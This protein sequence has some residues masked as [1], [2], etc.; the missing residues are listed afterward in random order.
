M[1]KVLIISASFGSGHVKAAEAVKKALIIRDST[2]KV[3]SIDALDYSD[4]VFKKVLPS[5]YLNIVNKFPWV[6]GYIY[7]RYNYSQ[8]EIKELGVKISEEI[9]YVIGKSNAAPL[10]KHIKDFNSQ[11]VV[12]THFFP[13]KIISELKSAGMLNCYIDPIFSEQFDKGKI[14]QKFNLEKSLPAILVLGGAAGRSPFLEIIESLEDVQGTVQILAVAG[15][16]KKLAQKLEI[17]KAKLKNKITVFGYAR[18]M[19]ELMRVSDILITKAG[20]LTVSEALSVDLPMLIVSP[21]PGQE[22]AN[23][24]FLIESGAAKIVTNIDLIGYKVNKILSN[25]QELS[26]MRL[27][28]HKIAKPHAAKEVVDIIFS[29]LNHGRA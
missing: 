25:P 4:A 23:A 6:W 10:I 22:Q 2:I 16:N 11:I 15:N 20:G 5:L 13:M 9:K 24:D 26:R 7:D 21:Y 19:H 28:C 17:A 14:R 18:N 27:N 12:C 3:E 8:E 1:K 29:Y